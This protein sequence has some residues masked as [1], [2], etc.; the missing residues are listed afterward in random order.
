MLQAPPPAAEA[1]AAPPPPQQPSEASTA[2]QLLGA[3]PTCPAALRDLRGALAAADGGAAL[4]ALLAGGGA[5][6]AGAAAQPGV[7]MYALQCTCALLFPS[8]ASSAAGDPGQGGAEAAELGGEPEALRLRLLRSGALAVLL[9]AATGLAAAATPPT[10]PPTHPEVAAAAH[11]AMLLLLHHLLAAA[12]EEEAAAAA[13]AAGPSATAEVSAGMAAAQLSE[14]ASMQVDSGAGQSS[15]AAAGSAASEADGGDG[16]VAA[17]AAAAP[18]ALRALAPAAAR[19]C[20]AMLCSALG[21]SAEQQQGQPGGVPAGGAAAAQPAVDPAAL[22]ELCR[23]ALE[24]LRRLAAASHG[25]VQA[26]LGA[27]SGALRA[28]VGALLL[29]PASAPLRRLAA[30][31]LPRFAAAAPPVHRWAFA[32][33]VRPLLARGGGGSGEQMVLCSHFVDTLEESEASR[34]WRPAGLPRAAS[35]L[36]AAAAPPAPRFCPGRSHSRARWRHKQV[37]RARQYS[38][39]I[40]PHPCRPA[41]STQHNL[42]SVV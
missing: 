21:C 4:R 9:D 20:V 24:L 35:P 18:A 8:I 29:H 37:L 41:H 27:R 12:E 22:P 2:L 40:P 34:C 16:E 19:Y 11:R 1:G 3:L 5:A 30:D 39:P 17:A 13:A 33:V 23:Q 32:H 36:A 42:P 31:W 14:P 26:L 6:P 15:D 28:A 38:R 7:L 25:A 10:P